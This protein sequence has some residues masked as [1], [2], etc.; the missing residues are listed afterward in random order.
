M[1][2]SYFF[3][4]MQHSCTRDTCL[5]TQSMSPG[6]SDLLFVWTAVT[7]GSSQG[8][9]L[10]HKLLGCN[11][12]DLEHLSWEMS[13]WEMSRGNAGICLIISA[14]ASVQNI[15]KWSLWWRDWLKSRSSKCFCLS[16]QKKLRGSISLD[17]RTDRTIIR[18]WHGFNFPS[19]SAHHHRVSSNCARTLKQKSSKAVVV[20]DKFTRDSENWGVR[21][22]VWGGA[23]LTIFYM[24]MGKEIL[25]QSLFADVSNFAWGRR[26]FLSILWARWY[27]GGHIVSESKKW[28]TFESISF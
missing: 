20:G 2:R 6:A 23:R 10:L 21:V 12:R 22:C 24:F 8:S 27:S 14:G 11:R 28:Q 4:E 18:E 25:R 26:F 9:Q 15:F 17:Q 16:R 7:S 1:Q 5:R 13:N 3:H 19:R